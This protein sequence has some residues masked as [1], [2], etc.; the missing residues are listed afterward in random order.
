MQYRPNM[1]RPWVQQYLMVNDGIFPI[2]DRPENWISEA[3]GFVYS[4]QF[5]GVCPW[6]HKV[7]LRAP[8]LGREKEPFAVLPMVSPGKK[9]LW[10]SVPG[11]VIYRYP[12]LDYN[13]WIRH[14]PKEVLNREVLMHIACKE[15]LR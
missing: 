3:G 8:I 5:I 11:S 10:G 14:L 15:R 13:P 1:D 9:P 6:T 7:W 2:F 4:D 12:E